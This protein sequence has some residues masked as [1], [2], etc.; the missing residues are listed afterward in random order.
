MMD[1][2]G[3]FVVKEKQAQAAIKRQYKNVSG[4]SH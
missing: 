1:E 4:A 3:N 2:E